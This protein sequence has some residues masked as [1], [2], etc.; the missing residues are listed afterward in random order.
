MTRL[1]RSHTRSH[2]HPYM[3]RHRAR[4]SRFQWWGPAAPSII[5]ALITW[6]LIAA[7]IQPLM[8]L[9]V[10]AEMEIALLPPTLEFVYSVGWFVFSNVIYPPLDLEPEQ[11]QRGGTERERE[12]ASERIAALRLAEKRMRDIGFLWSFVSRNLMPRKVLSG[13]NIEALLND[14]IN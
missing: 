4:L 7:Q 12:R 9:S 8:L 2:T 11:Q 13:T 3:Y 14:I 10:Y 1:S 6:L 5:T